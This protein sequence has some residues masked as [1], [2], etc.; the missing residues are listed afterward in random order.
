MF[1]LLTT[2]S[3]APHSVLQLTL[4]GLWGGETVVRATVV[5]ALADGIALAV[6]G[7]ADEM[8]ARLLTKPVSQNTLD[9]IR[10]L[11]QMEKILLAAKAD[12]TQI[13]SENLEEIIDQFEDV[14]VDVEERARRAKVRVF[15]E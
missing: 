15:C 11:S 6:E 5:A 12:R 7:N 13:R 3:V 1:L 9:Q 2:E 14:S 10:G 4:R 8:L